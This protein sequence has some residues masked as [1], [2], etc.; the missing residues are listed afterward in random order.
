MADSDQVRQCRDLAV[1]LTVGCESAPDS[2]EHDAASSSYEYDYEEQTTASNS[3]EDDTIPAKG[4]TMPFPTSDFDEELPSVEESKDDEYE[5]DNDD[6]MDV[7]FGED[8]RRETELLLHE[9]Q[10]LIQ[11]QHDQDALPLSPINETNKMESGDSGAELAQPIAMKSQEFTDNAVDVSV[12]FEEQYG[13]DEDFMDGEDDQDEEQEEFE[14]YASD[15]DD[16]KDEDA[17]C[18]TPSVE[19]SEP[20]SHK[21]AVSREVHQVESAD[22]TMV[23]SA[24]VDNASTP[25][26]HAIP[27][28]TDMPAQIS[29]MQEAEMLPLEQ[30]AADRHELTATSEP[31]E[32]VSEKKAADS[33]KC[34]KP[35]T[36]SSPQTQNSSNKGAAN[37]DS[38]AKQPVVSRPK[39]PA[40]VN[41][42]VSYTEARVVARP[43]R[44]IAAEKNKRVAES[45]ARISPPKEIGLTRERPRELRLKTT[46]S[47][48]QQ[49]TTTSAS[50]SVNTKQT[51]PRP[52][53]T[54]SDSGMV[55]QKK[56][57]EVRDPEA[58]SMAQ[59]S[60]SSLATEYTHVTMVR[61]RSPPKSLGR[62]A[63][64]ASRS[65]EKVSAYTP[66][67]YVEEYELP[68]RKA[69]VFKQ[70][71]RTEKTPRPEESRHKLTPVKSPPNLRID[72]PSM[73]KTK[74]DWLFLNM[75]RHGGGISKYESF[76]PK[77]VAAAPSKPTSGGPHRPYSAHMSYASSQE[78]A[79]H[80]ERNWAPIKPHESAIPPYDSIL[81]KF[82]TTV[83]SPVIQR[84]IYQTQLND[85][86]PQ[87]AYVLEKR[88]EKQWKQAGAAEAFG[89]V[90]TSYKTDIVALPSNTGTI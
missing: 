12:D 65:P 64:A 63:G 59:D 53:R 32:P 20:P 8:N 24:I 62:A 43:N 47:T 4:E 39:R 10:L 25:S 49:S 71:K 56:E 80:A 31:I 82:C 16:I 60:S 34:E 44:P 17:I 87:L 29:P 89:A 3:G 6:Y 33:S 46:R 83:T 86:S 42:P 76:V 68:P 38:V 75:F 2:V 35:P 22:S 54:K 57:E 15:G 77:L 1:F 36:Q 19:W 45:P 7:H 13:G 67:A 14:Q 88:V 11:R 85:L 90:S 48:V 61:P 58:S 84:Q 30:P 5:E 26:D 69:P 78:D 70:Q 81:D 28:A 9:A 79:I 55:V 37:A 18:L 41:A 21:E 50:S 73:D 27:P 40:P 66:R 23:V 52:T 72:L 51:S 74:R